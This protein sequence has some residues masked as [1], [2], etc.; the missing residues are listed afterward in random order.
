MGWIRNSK[1]LW[2]S[3]AIII[4]VVV[5]SGAFVFYEESEINKQGFTE[6]S[7]QKANRIRGLAAYD[8]HD[9]VTALRLFQQLAQQGDPKAQANVGLMYHDGKGVTQNFSE[10]LKWYRQAAS[11][12]NSAAQF[13]L[14]NMYYS[15][16]GVNQ[17]YG[18][19]I[20]WFSKA[21]AQGNL[22]AINNLGAIHARGQGVKLD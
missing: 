22:D 1:I 11:E 13:N 18:D 21:A 19:A 7:L 6:S 4:T 15:G 8:R 14:A 9:Y 20:K 16:Q 5:I 10:A 3:G 17:N 2:V 12:G